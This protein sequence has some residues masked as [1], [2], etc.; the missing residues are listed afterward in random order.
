MSDTKKNAIEQRLDHIEALWNAFADKPDARRCRWL[1][2]IDERRMIDV[3]VEVQYDES[4]AV[5]DVFV[6]LEDAG[7]EPGGCEEFA[8]GKKNLKTKKAAS[9]LKVWKE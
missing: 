6:R 3:F 7:G 5:P 8:S 2:S 1:V 9:Y 4:G